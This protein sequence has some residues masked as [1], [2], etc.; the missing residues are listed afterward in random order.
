[1]SV[2]IAT[3]SDFIETPPNRIAC[4]FSGAGPR[5]R[6]WA[7]R[8]RRHTPRIPPPLPAS[9]HE[10]NTAPAG[11]P[12]AWLTPVVKEISPLLAQNEQNTAL[13]G[14]PGRRIFHG[15]PPPF[16]QGRFFFHPSHA[17]APQ[18]GH[19]WPCSAPSVPTRDKTRPARTI[20]QSTFFRQQ[21]ESCLG[22]TQ[23]PLLP[24]KFHLAHGRR[25][26]DLRSLRHRG[27]APCRAAASTPG[28][29]GV[30]PRGCMKERS[31]LRST[32]WSFGVPL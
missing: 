19:N 22:P 17:P 3:F 11:Q 23:N 5:R 18:A 10:R 9:L 27:Q 29:L 15:T 25:S 20:P 16:T 32:G 6:P 7:L 12:T 31:P 21:G 26:Q 4:D 1:M 14:V 30:V 24:G 13:F 28:A 2:G 8:P